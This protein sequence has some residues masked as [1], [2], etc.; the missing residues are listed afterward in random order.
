M[1]RLL[2]CLSFASLALA[3][4]TAEAADPAAYL[5]APADGAVVKGPVT[6]VFGLR[7]PWGVAPAGINLPDTGHH[8]L[9]IDA[10]LPDLTKAVPKDARHLHF[11]GGQTETTLT[12]APGKHT[13]QLLLGDFA[14][15][16]HQPPVVSA[17]ITIT[18]E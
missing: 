18:V 8:H 5:I 11:G 7:A 9:L 6:V 4:G 10:P 16:P 15:V 12:L 3:L 14:H 13:L 2:T 1:K 17:P